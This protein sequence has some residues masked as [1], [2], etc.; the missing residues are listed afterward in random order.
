MDNILLFMDL[1]PFKET[2]N[3]VAKILCNNFWYEKLYGEKPTE[4]IG[5][6]SFKLQKLQVLP[7]NRSQ[8]VSRLLNLDSRK[9]KKTAKIESVIE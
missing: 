9:P 6:T 8:L 4:Q 2:R 5:K 3:Y 7:K 1:I